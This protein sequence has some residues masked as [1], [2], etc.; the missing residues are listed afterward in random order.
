MRFEWDERKRRGNLAKHGL[1]FAD[2]GDFD[3]ENATWSEDDS[4]G[5][6]E[7][8]IR[9]IGPFRGKLAFVVWTER[10]SG[11]TRIISFRPATPFEKK[12]YRNEFG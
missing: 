8:R 6:G 4:E 7:Q 11:V 12:V 5:F 10:A 3:W 1:D 9:S 2:V